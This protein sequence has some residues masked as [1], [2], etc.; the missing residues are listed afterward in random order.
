[1]GEVN[2]ENM[3]K[4]TITETH[5]DDAGGCAGCVIS[6]CPPL[7]LTAYTELKFEDSDGIIIYGDEKQKIELYKDWAAF[8]GEIQNPE[9]SA[10][11]PFFKTANG[12]GSL[13]APLDEVLNT[14]RPVLSKYG[15]G[16]FQSPTYKSGQVSV[17]TILVHKSGCAINFPTFSIPIQKNDAQG[18]IAGITYARR[19]VLNPILCTHGETDDDGNACSGK[20]VK[21]E[22]KPESKPEAN[23]DDAVPE[24][25]NTR[26]KVIEIAK[27]LIADGVD[28]AEVNKRIESVCNVRNI[29]S[30]NDVKLLNATVAALNEMK[31]D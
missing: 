31:K 27:Q 12:K 7:T 11:N 13:Y 26:K 9:N 22:S 6:G 15:F 1:M 23:K 16:L 14:A 17:K 25:M 28:R 4:P 19:G 18:V 2:T 10:T 30:V 8:V 20:E 5:I 29:N 24:V 21:K 3:Y